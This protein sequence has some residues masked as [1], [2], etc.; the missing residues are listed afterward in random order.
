MITD[1]QIIEQLAR[2][3]NRHGSYAFADDEEGC[4]EYE[5]CLVLLEWLASEVER[6]ALTAPARAA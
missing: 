2:H 4:A 6:P 5:R 3:I 1:R